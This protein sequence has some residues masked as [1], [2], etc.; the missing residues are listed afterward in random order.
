MFHDSDVDVLVVLKLLPVGEYIA[1]FQDLRSEFHSQPSEV[2]GLTLHY[3]GPSCIV[4]INECHAL[5][6]KPFG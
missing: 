2:N 4:L 6:L 5:K 3:A 1:F